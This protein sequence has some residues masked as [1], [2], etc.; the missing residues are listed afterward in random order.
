MID[1]KPACAE[2][3]NVLAALTD[4]HL[5]EPTPCAEYRVRDL[6]EHVDQVAHGFIGLAGGSSSEEDSPVAH[7]MGL[8]DAWDDS[9][10]WDGSSGGDVGLSNATWGKIALTE[11]VVHG[12]DL[13]VA[14]GQ[15]FELPE[16]TLQACLAHVATF[17]PNA[18]VPE[19]WGTPV[20]LAPGASSLHRILAVTGRD[21]EWRPQPV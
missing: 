2:M 3:R 14:S 11:M 15:T 1:L 6:V 20:E 10:A 18:P 9:A 17:V 7:V 13:A 5:A 16:D 12:W 19:L 4:R 8:G 21:P